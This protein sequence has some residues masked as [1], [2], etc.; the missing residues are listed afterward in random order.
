M[1]FVNQGVSSIEGKNAFEAY[2]DEIQG[3]KCSA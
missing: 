1:R 2:F 3:E